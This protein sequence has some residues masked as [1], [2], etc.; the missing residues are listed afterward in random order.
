MRASAIL[1]VKDAKLCGTV[2]DPEDST[3][4]VAGVNTEFFVD[5]TEPLKVLKQV[6][7]KLTWPLGDLPDGYEFLLVVP[8]RRHGPGYQSSAAP[9]KAASELS[10]LT[11]KT[12]A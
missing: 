10:G 12:A 1:Y 5:H 2:F 7:R 4:L 8:A 9:G 6:R 11:Q 3:G